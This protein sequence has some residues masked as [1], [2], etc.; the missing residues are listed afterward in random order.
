[1]PFLF[2]PLQSRAALQKARVH[3]ERWEW[4]LSA[5]WAP[6]LYVVAFDPELPGSGL[7]ARMFAPA[8]EITE[9]PATG[10]AATALGGY[11]VPGAA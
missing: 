7:R 8:M 9:D 10:A 6:H 11:P 1:V 4:K 2:I 3:R 5:Y